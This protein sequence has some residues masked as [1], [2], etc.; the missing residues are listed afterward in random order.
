MAVLRAFLALGVC[1]LLGDQTL[2]KNDAPCQLS[3]WNNGY[4]TFVK[5]HIR[6][7]TPTSLDQNEWEKYIRNNGGCDRPTQSFLKQKDLD[8]VKDVCTDKG[9]KTFKENLCI[10]KQSFTFVTVRSEPGTCGIRSVR[11]ETKHLI[12]A[13]EV[14]E[15]Q[16]LPVHF[17]GN[18][19]NLKPG[20]N[21]KSCQDP[22]AK[23]HAP[24]F[25]MTWLPLLSVLLVI[26]HG[27]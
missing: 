3:K 10:S 13:C 12:L 18:P 5:R 16:C 11:E 17:E 19:E 23:G 22:K 27:Y 24:S 2:A 21:A 6:S 7:G 15:N 20:N 14:L 8:M 25:K 26:I 1:L 9:G 4:N